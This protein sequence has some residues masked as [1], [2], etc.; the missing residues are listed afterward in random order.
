VQL[1]R[2]QTLQPAPQVRDPEK[3]RQAEHWFQQGLDFEERGGA[4][5][6]AK[7]AYERAVDLNPEAAGAWVNLGTLHYRGGEVRAAEHYYRRAL[8]VSPDYALA[9]FNLGNVCEELG[10]L[11]EAAECYER[12]VE[13]QPGYADAH[14][15]L[16]LVYERTGEPMRA[17]KH[18]RDYLRLDPASPWA[19]IARQ[20]L[21]GLLEVTQGGGGL[22][23]ENTGLGPH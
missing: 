7:A 9:H 22:R 8:D 15:N 4:S 19:G 18:W 6:E 20:Q 10:R 14:Y 12:S 3:L 17:A 23:G 21:Q 2:V 5:G 1:E 16:A 13:L 11:K